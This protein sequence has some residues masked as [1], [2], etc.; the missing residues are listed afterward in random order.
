MKDIA[1]ET[2]LSQVGKASSNVTLPLYFSTSQDLSS[3]ELRLICH[4]QG[5]HYPKSLHKRGIFTLHLYCRKNSNLQCCTYIKVSHQEQNQLWFLSFM[6]RIWVTP[7][8][9]KCDLL[10]W[11][12]YQSL[13]W[14][15]WPVDA[16]SS[17]L[18]YEIWKIVLLSWGLSNTVGKRKLLKLDCVLD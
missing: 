7:R 18:I 5:T 9:A 13:T 17:I 14:K 11:A 4:L 1:A 8:W 15:K 10:G 16:Q 3:I 2:K 12:P 6:R